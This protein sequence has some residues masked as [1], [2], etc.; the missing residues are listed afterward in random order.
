[1]GARN[2]STSIEFYAGAWHDTVPTCFVIQ[3]F[4]KRIMIDCG[5][6]PWS[7]T[8][9]SLPKDIDY[10]ILT[11]PHLDHIGRIVEWW[12]KNKQCPI[13]APEGS[14]SAIQVWLEW[15]H[16][17][18][19][20]KQWIDEYKEAKVWLNNAANDINAIIWYLQGDSNQEQVHRNRNGRTE[21]TMEH[22]RKI[23]RMKNR[24]SMRETNYDKTIE[25]IQHKL[26]LWGYDLRNMEHW[27][28]IGERL[29]I[30]QGRQQSHANYVRNL[31]NELVREKHGESL[32]ELAHKDVVTERDV[33]ECVKSI[34]EVTIGRFYQIFSWFE[35][36]KKWGW[37]RKSIE[38][39]FE[40]SWHLYSAVAWMVFMKLGKKETIRI[41]ATGDMG[42]DKLS[43]PPYP[44]SHIPDELHHTNDAVI[45]E[46]TYGNRNH[47]DNDQSRFVDREAALTEYDRILIEAIESG[48]D[49]VIPV[50]SLDRPVFGAYEIVTRLFERWSELWKK[51]KINPEKV[52]ILYKGYDLEKFLPKRT[53]VWKKIQKYFKFLTSDRMN[54][55]EKKWKK[56]RIIFAAW[57]FLPETSPAAD[58]LARTLTRK[59]TVVIFINYCG[60]DESNAR[61]LLRGEPVQVKKKVKDWGR[62]EC[63]IQTSPDRCHDIKW[64]S[65]HADQDTLLKHIETL[66]KPEWTK[67]FI[68]HASKESGEW[69]RDRIREKFRRKIIPVLPRNRD[70]RPIKFVPVKK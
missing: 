3:H 33:Q 38:I 2:H 68:N 49:V 39:R 48:A 57:G 23:A 61:K 50:I 47:F 10:A 20:W 59:D 27:E 60:D 12:M 58:I 11:H 24:T 43:S 17:I 22:D 44:R 31:L 54:G 14:K 65:G 56:S 16:R 7:T 32:A 42:N 21:E 46:G 64:F 8:H 5:L 67:V 51:A 53:A 41:A 26:W 70:P 34:R 1:M 15:T 36:W 6:A 66:S 62:I 25:S 45:C 55:L 28:I 29:W 40:N 13:F 18:S 30:T 52:E 69:L 4:N 37:D 9:Y 35:E 63:T 19:S